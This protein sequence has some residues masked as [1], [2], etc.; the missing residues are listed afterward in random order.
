MTIF[1]S[2]YANL[3]NIPTNIVPVAISQ[4][5]PDWYKGKKLRRLAPSQE[6]LRLY[7]SGQ[8]TE[9][10]YVERYKT[11]TLS[12]F[13][14][15]TLCQNLYDYFGGKDVCLMCFEKP[16]DFCHR[17]LVSEWFRDAGYDAREWAVQMEQFS[18]FDDIP[19]EEE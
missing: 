7:K 15:R 5:P 6:L 13:D 8:I 12:Q 19:G 16:G 18:L 3:R 1:T 17:H 2:Y 11:E 14:P 4:F 10:G 9:D